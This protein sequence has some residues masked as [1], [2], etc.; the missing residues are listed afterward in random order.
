VP[1]DM[2][3]TKSAQM[4]GTDHF[5]NVPKPEIQVIRTRSAENER[6]IGARSARGVEGC[7][8]TIT[9]GFS[10]PARAGI[11]VCN[12]VVGLL[13]CCRVRVR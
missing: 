11:G 13:I 12:F 8:C 7:A 4:R 9:I 1:K 6:Q 10:C 5:G 2:V 3:K